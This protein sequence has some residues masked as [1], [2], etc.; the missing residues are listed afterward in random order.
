MRT[1]SPPPLHDVSYCQFKK[2]SMSKG[3]ERLSMK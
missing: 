1:G 3:V 2:R